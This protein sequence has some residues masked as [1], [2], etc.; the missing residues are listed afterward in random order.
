MIKNLNSA[1]IIPVIALATVILFYF[2]LLKK[3]NYPKAFK[4][5]IIIILVLAFMLNFLWEMAQMPLF[6]NMP[7][8]WETALFCTLASIADCIMVL[9]LYVGFGLMYKNF[10]WFRQPRLL[11]VVL[12]VITGGVGAVLIEKKY[13]LL[14]NWV[15]SSCMPVVPVVDV[16]L[17]PLLQFMVLPA[18][19]FYV[20]ST[21]VGSIVK[22]KGV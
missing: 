21:V 17:S 7:F 3:T 5:I 11:Q 8:N 14:G 20:A 12:L 6:K 9:L 15:Y 10:M 13:L 19:I 2:L 22:D 18:I 1:F 16:G 4:R